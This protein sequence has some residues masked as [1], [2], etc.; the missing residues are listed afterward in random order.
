MVFKGC[1]RHEHLKGL[2][3]VWFLDNYVEVEQTIVKR[4]CQLL[5]EFL[6]CLFPEIVYEVFASYK[7]RMN[8]KYYKALVDIHLFLGSVFC[9]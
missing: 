4:E 3:F 2:L 5:F 8:H 1:Q 7:G 9:S 6:G